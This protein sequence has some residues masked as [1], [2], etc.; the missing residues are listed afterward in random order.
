MTASQPLFSIIIP[1]YNKRDEIGR[2]LKSVLDQTF[3]DFEIIVI[4]DGSTD[5]GEE[6]VGAITDRRVQLLHQ[7]NSG[8]GAA[9]NAGIKY[10]NGWFISFLDADDSWATDH[11]HVIL[12]LILK[13]PLAGAY[14][15]SFSYKKEG[16]NGVYPVVFKRNLPHP[17]EGL[18]LNYLDILV[19]E[20]SPIIT[21]SICVRKSLLEQ[22]AGFDIQLP[23]AQDVDL[24]IRIFLKSTIA[25][26]TKATSFYHLGTANQVTKS[27]DRPARYFIFIKKL[28]VYIN[29][30]MVCFNHRR[31]LTQMQYT[32]GR[33]MT[34]E[35]LLRGDYP[36][37]QKG[38]SWNA[39]RYNSYAQL[40]LRIIMTIIPAIFFKFTFYFLTLMRSKIAKSLQKLL[41]L[42]T[43]R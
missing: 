21:N 35:A 23:L 24:W 27:S 41:R 16:I 5:G 34:R 39:L 3:Q 1:L 2:A 43:H 6:E 36:T 4:N 29:D 40:S 13:F 14:C 31:L 15:T 30:K 25:Y 9:R 11:L 28:T 10:A 26:S 17:W 18:L 7:K 33:N 8:Q 12:G 38:I 42:S 19:N 20:T 37:V 22:L 32:F